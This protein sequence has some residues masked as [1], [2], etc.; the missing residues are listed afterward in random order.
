MSSFT[1]PTSLV[2]LGAWGILFANGLRAEP[3][4][5]TILYSLS[6]P[7][8]H[9]HYV[10]VEC[11]FPTAGESE[12]ELV[13]AAWTPGSYLIREYAK[14][15]EGLQARTNS[16]SKLRVEKSSKNRWRVRTEASPTVTVFY[17]VYCHEMSVRAN[18]VDRD[19]AVLNGASTF[20][21]LANSPAQR[22]EVFLK[23]QKGG[24]G[25]SPDSMLPRHAP[26]IS[27]RKISI[28]SSMRPFFS[29]IRRCT[30]SMSRTS[31]I[32]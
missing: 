22:H 18:W 16:G 27:S 28:H 12:I 23:L 14:H 30:S 32:S 11:N 13:M 2:A 26:T 3:T 6:F 5:D 15:V 7:R 17:R 25:P 21:T 24:Q 31:P 8:P 29:A 1:T 4:A 10:E 20:I 9:T 19:F